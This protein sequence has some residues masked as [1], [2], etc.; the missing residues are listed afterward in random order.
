[1]AGL[2][3]VTAIAAGGSTQYAVRADG[4]V[5]AWGWNFDGALGNGSTV[6][7]SVEPVQVTGLSG[8]TAVASGGATYALR[9]DGT[10]WSWGQ[11]RNGQLGDGVPC[12]PEP[13]TRCESRVPVQV[14]GLT[15]VT[16]IAAGDYNGY[17]ARADGTAWSWGSN[18]MG[19]L[20]NG[21]DCD[22]YPCESRVPVRVAGLTDV[23]RVASFDSGGYAL[24]ADGSVRAWGE[25]NDGQLANESVFGY[26]TVPVP[27]I[28]VAG[29]SAVAGSR[30]AGFAL[31]PNP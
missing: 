3:G 24:R 12:S 23:T 17:A 18:V 21:S 2:T 6:D 16:S 11:N 28:G 1:M 10:V 7:Y 20:G 9:D 22:P 25:N 27:V 5:W 26:S 19:A 4:T 29:V 8:V 30:G 13:F 15:G 14:S 31:V